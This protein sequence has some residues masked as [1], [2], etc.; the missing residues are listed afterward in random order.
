VLVLAGCATLP[1]TSAV[2]Q[3]TVSSPKLGQSYPQLIPVGPTSGERP[4]D[5]VRG[6]LAASASFADGHHVAHEYLAPHVPWNPTSAATVVSTIHVTTRVIPAGNAPNGAKSTAIVEF[7]GQRLATLTASGQYVQSSGSSHATFSLVLEGGQWRITKL[8][9][10]HELI[11]Q[12]D[13]FERVY[14]ARNLY[15]YSPTPTQQPGSARHSVKHLVPDPIYVPEQGT[16]TTSAQAPALSLVS[17]LRAA[18][19]AGPLQGS[20]TRTAFPPGTTVLGVQVVGTQAVVDLGGQAVRASQQQLSEMAAQIALTLTGSSYSPSAI[21][22]VELQVNHVTKRKLLHATDFADVAP[23]VPAGQLYYIS[24]NRV[25]R[26]GGAQLSRQQSWLTG[27]PPPRVSQIAV[28]PV[29]SGVI[30]QIAGLVPDQHG[31]LVYIGLADRKTGV[32]SQHLGGACSSLS[33]DSQGNVWIAAGSKVWMLPAGGRAALRVVIGD[34]PPGESVTGLRVAPDNT[35][36]AVLGRD[37][38]GQAHLWLGAIQNG[39]IDRRPGSIDQVDI[40]T[41]GSM[42][43]IGADIPDP[44]SLAWYDPD[45]VMVLSGGGGSH[46]LFE[47]PVNGGSSTRIDTPP[48]AGLV[49]LAATG[50]GQQPALAVATSSGRI[51]VSNGV[52]TNGATTW[53]QLSQKGRAPAFSG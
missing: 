7:T 32:H 43:Q 35:R 40:G 49:W 8:P 53:T 28:Q 42:L 36:V 25:W 13:D 12:N 31:C 33:V 15:F 24:G 52:T 46:Q 48:G 50:P 4:Q 14:L 47:V 17:A 30:P 11:L 3:E 21:R 38:Q 51:E 37:G 23:A 2:Q 34:L 44:Q 18:P 27:D 6:F 45:H 22:S 26:Y 29:P 39:P 41:P 5:I 20:G 19:S 1:T 9:N 16:N 10:S